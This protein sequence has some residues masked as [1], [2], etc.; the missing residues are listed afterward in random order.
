[1]FVEFRRPSDKSLAYCPDG[2]LG[3]VGYADFPQDMLDV[4]LHRFV[5]DAESSGNFLVRKSES[6]LFKDFVFSAG[7]GGLD[8]Q[9]YAWGH[10]GPGYATQFFVG[11][12][13]FAP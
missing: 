2:S 11:P 8:L 9:R 10:Q 12:D 5:A 13:R 3:S 1:M 4:F 6:E 7:K